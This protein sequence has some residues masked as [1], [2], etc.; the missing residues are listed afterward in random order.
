MKI[1]V[2]FIKDVEL[3]GKT[4]LKNS[5]IEVEDRDNDLWVYGESGHS[6]ILSPLE[7]VIITGRELFT[8]DDMYSM[9]DWSTE[10]Y[11]SDRKDYESKITTLEKQVRILTDINLVLEERLYEQRK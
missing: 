6:K 9:A 11:L 8:M 1:K 5:I 2:R 3:V 10:P 4:F 7:V